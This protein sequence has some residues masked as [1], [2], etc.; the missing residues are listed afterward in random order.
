MKNISWLFLLL[1][2]FFLLVPGTLLA[3]NAFDGTWALESDQTELPKKPDIYL[4]QGGIYQC[5]TCVP[6]IKV[7]ADGKSYP[8]AGSPYFSS[9]SVRTVDSRDLQ[10]T[11]TQKG[12]TVYTEN[13]SVSPDGNLLMQKVTD[14]S[15][16]NGE[17]VIAEETFERIGAPPVSGNMISGLWQAHRIHFSSANGTTVTYHATANGLQVS[18]PGG[19]G[20]DAKFDGKE[21]RIRG[22]PVRST[23][24]LKRVNARTIEETDR[25]EGVVHYRL[26]MAVS[27]DGKTMKV[28]ELDKER[29]TK[30][31]YRMEKQSGLNH[32]PKP[33]A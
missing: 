21:Y 11:E 3:Q 32:P 14:S 17:P 23:V 8:V 29:G 6:A 30:T 25:D 18:T 9:I 16:P 7:H 24:T 33:T 28:T 1:S 12:K 13:D 19:E 27:R 2:F 10:I 20:Y 4:L 22:V 26:R 15:A 31:T 5:S